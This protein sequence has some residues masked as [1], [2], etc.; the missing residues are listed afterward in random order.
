MAAPHVAAAGALVKSVH[1]SWTNV[2]IRDRLQETARDLG[3]AGWDEFYGHGLLDLAAAVGL[4]DPPAVTISGP[5]R[6]QP[7]ATCT[8]DAN[9]TSGDPPFTYYWTGEVQPYGTTDPWYTGTKDSGQLADHFTLRVEV[10]NA[11]GSDI[12]EI[13]VYE[14]PDARICI[15]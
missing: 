1:S 10:S 12:D 13:I 5:T 8:W 11:A 9:V 7:G 6:I 2:Q 14:D 15:I 4:G 3:S